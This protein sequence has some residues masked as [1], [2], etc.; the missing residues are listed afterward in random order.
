VFSR[1]AKESDLYHAVGFNSAVKLIVLQVYLIWRRIRIGVFPSFFSVGLFSSCW[2]LKADRLSIERRGMGEIPGGFYEINRMAIELARSFFDE[3]LAG[4]KHLVF[5]SRPEEADRCRYYVKKQLAQDFFEI[6]T[7]LSLV[8][9]FSPSGRIV[10]LDTPAHRFAVREFCRRKGLSFEID[11]IRLTFLYLLLPCGYY[12]RLLHRIARG[13][14][15]WRRKVFVKFY[16]EAV[17][18]LKRPTLRDDILIDEFRFR[19]DEAVFYAR[20]DSGARREAAREITAA[21]YRVV[22]I[23]RCPLNIRKGL[24]AFFFIFVLQPMLLTLIALAAGRVYL[25]E[26]IFSFFADSVH[27]FLFLT[28]YRAAFH[29]STSEHGEIA[30][31]IIMN[32]AGCRNVLYHWSDMTVMKAV[33]HAF[34]AHNDYYT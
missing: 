32:R 17:W 3:R 9:A 4:K 2:F 15:R 33:T 11:W 21:G 23:R 20:M 6:L 25:V 27:H 26:A 1:Q 19:K 13:G 28:N 8:A 10:A 12:L 5:M 14:V 31:T 34:T 22:D 16:K 24:T 29:L 30:E 18:G 7:G